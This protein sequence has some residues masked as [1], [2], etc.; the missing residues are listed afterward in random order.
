MSLANAKQDIEQI[1]RVREEPAEPSE[2]SE[3]ETFTCPIEGCNRTVIGSPGHLRNHVSQSSDI[4]HQFR[5]LNE[6]LE[7]EF[8][9]GKYHA[10]WGPGLSKDDEEDRESIYEPGDPWGPGI[11]WIEL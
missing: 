6:N 8:N 1:R 9:E 10:S 5:T 11:P 3:T 7:I 4:G 2:E